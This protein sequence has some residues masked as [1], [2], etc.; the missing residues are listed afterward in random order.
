MSAFSATKLK[1]GQLALTSSASLSRNRLA[2]TGP[3]GVVDMT[4]EP[5]TDDTDNYFLP[6]GGAEKVIDEMG[7]RAAAAG[8]ANLSNPYQNV[9]EDAAMEQVI[10][11]SVAE[12]KGTVLS[13]DIGDVVEDSVTASF[14]SDGVIAVGGNVE[15]PADSPVKKRS[16]SDREI[17]FQ[18]RTFNHVSGMLLDGT[19][20]TQDAIFSLMEKMGADEN[21]MAKMIVKSKTVKGTPAEGESPKMAEQLIKTEKLVL[22]RA[23]DK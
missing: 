20:A 6:G 11:R 12:Q 13:L 1:S 4:K 10:A 23:S 5:D 8:L 18:E 2:G 22:K 17:E 7:K 3:V 19:P 21:N 9:G 14:G 15:A 16:K